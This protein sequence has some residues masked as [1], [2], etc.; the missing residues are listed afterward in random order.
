M[1]AAANAGVDSAFVRRPHREGY[2]LDAEPT[3]EIAGL[4]EL[5]ALVR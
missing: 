2:A 5:P 4:D 3:H 1:L